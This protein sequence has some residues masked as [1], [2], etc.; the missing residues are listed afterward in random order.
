M[1]HASKKKPLA[2]IVERTRVILPPDI[3]EESNNSDDSE[4]EFSQYGD[5]RNETDEG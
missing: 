3:F 2:L 1:F 5:I 4:N